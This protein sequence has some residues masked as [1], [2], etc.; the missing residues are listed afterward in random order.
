[1]VQH[2]CEHR[3]TLLVGTQT[4]DALC[5]RGVH[6][7]LGATPLH[8]NEFAQDVRHRLGAQGGGVQ[9]DRHEQRVLGPQRDVEQRGALGGGQRSQA[10]TAQPGPIRLVQGAGHRPALVPQA[11]GQRVAGQPA[12]AAVGDQGVQ[13]GVGGGVVGLTRATE[14]AR[15]GGEQHERRQAHA[16]GQLVQVH[17]GVDL[18]A[19][20]GV[21]L[22]GG[23][24]REHAVGQHTGGVHDGGQGAIRQQ[25]G[26]CR[27]VGDVA[28]GDLDLRALVGQLRDEFASALGVQA[29]AAGQQ[30]A[31]HPVLGDQVPG[32]DLAQRA[33]PAGDQHSA[34]PR[35]LHSGLF[36]GPDQARCQH[37]SR[38][39]Q[40][41]RLA[42]LHGGHQLRG[43]AVGV[44]QHEAVGVLRLRGPDQ[45][46]HR[47]V[48]QVLGER[49][50]GQHHQAGG[51]VAGEPVADHGQ[52]PVRGL[53]G[54]LGEV[55]FSRH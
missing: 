38:T 50:A 51:A 46:P 42:G 49:T 5:E 37:L 53:A 34:V 9:V 52:G 36:A 10:A 28:R 15:H 30:Q 11:P 8:G 20:H 17:R 45:A 48:H 40:E 35:E 7:G 44:D 2:H 27:P 43:V 32:E 31:A 25:L 1:M 13:E 39:E 16:T 19:Q 21:D 54:G 18:G 26:Q 12:V 4:G 24:R 6:C 14:H 22:L 33:G 41:L 29:A 47:G 3:G 55:D 23:Q